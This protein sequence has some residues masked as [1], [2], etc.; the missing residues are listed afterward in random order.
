MLYLTLHRILKL[1]HAMRNHI[2]SASVATK[3]QER[4]SLM[5]ILDFKCNK[6]FS[7]SD[8]LKI[9]MGSHTGEKPYQCNQCAKSFSYIGNLKSHLMT[10]TG[11]KPHKCNK[12]DKSF[13]HTPNLKSHLR[14]HTGEKPY[15]CSE[16]TK[17]FSANI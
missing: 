16:C 1:N 7:R 14:I 11:V 8:D 5:G 3:S 15:H 6:V 9:H 2:S 10:H 12:C 13:S 17:M 4:K